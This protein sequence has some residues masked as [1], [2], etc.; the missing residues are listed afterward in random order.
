MINKARGPQ[1][2]EAGRMLGLE[3]IRFACAL[4]VLIWHYQ[5]FFQMVGAPAYVRVDQPLY[6][7]LA[8]FY[9]YGQFGVQLFWGISGF[10]FFWKYGEVIYEGSVSASRFFWLRFSRLYPLHLVTLLSV[11]VLQ[12]VYQTLTGN[13]FV[14]DG[15]NL[16]NFFLQLG[17][18]TQWGAPSPYTFNGPIWSV[19]A[20][21]L[22]YA[23]FFFLVRKFGASIWLSGAAILSS[24]SAM[25]AGIDSPAIACSAFFF[26]GGASAQFVAKSMKQD[27]INGPRFVASAMLAAVLGGAWWIGILGAAEALP[28]TLLLAMPPLLFLAAQNWPLLERWEAPIQAAGNLTYSSYLCHFPLQLIVAVVTA[29]S[30]WA[31]PVASPLFLAA[32]LGSSLVAA[33]LVYIRFERPAQDW[34]RSLA[35]RREPAIA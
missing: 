22:V 10:I 13:S 33:R 30:G 9:E 7:I 6:F 4:G 28:F 17:F 14:Y 5:H 34:I 31:M 26:A 21:V 19:S 8:L 3:V 29:A 2:T 15:N 12:L 25:I 11:L 18:A 20:E 16:P 23:V 1:P 24:V 27:D 35:L 32:Y